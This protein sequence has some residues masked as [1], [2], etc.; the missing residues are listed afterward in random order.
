MT[1]IAF[2]I[3]AKI[4]K[5]FLLIRTINMHGSLPFI[6]VDKV[7]NSKERIDHEK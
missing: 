6:D 3:V 5:L 2:D 1:K 4:T 7:S